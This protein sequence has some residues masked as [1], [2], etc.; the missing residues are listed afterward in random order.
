MFPFYSTLCKANHQ[1]I[2]NYKIYLIF[3]SQIYSDNIILIITFKILSAYQNILSHALLKHKTKY[4]HSKK[5]LNL[6]TTTV[7]F[8]FVVCVYSLDTILIKTWLN[9]D[10]MFG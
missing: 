6:T 2:N 4:L 10:I 5:N 7:L 3:Q 9:I 8:P 1:F